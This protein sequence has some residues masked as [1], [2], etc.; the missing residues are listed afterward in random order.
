[1][2]DETLNGF[3]YG[4][5]WLLYFALFVMIIGGVVKEN[6]QRKKF[7]WNFDEVKKI[8]KMGIIQYLTFSLVL[9]LLVPYLITRFFVPVYLPGRY[10]IVTFIPF[11]VL[12]SGISYKFA[13][14]RILWIFFILFFIVFIL[15][16]Y[17]RYKPNFVYSDRWKTQILSNNSKDGDIVMFLGTERMG[18]EYYLKRF[19]NLKKLECFSFPEDTDN[20]HPGWSNFKKMGDKEIKELNY[21]INKI[22]KAMAQNDI[23]LWVFWDHNRS[24]NEEIENILSVSFKKIAEIHKKNGNLLMTVYERKNS[25]KKK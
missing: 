21:K 25:H 10:T 11:V 24:D 23:R 20:E 1:M 14:K 8:I 22:K 18:V 9:L 17:Q 2:I 6:I 7:F 16:N 15:P 19:N 5:G 12:I 13:D 3:Y 4:E